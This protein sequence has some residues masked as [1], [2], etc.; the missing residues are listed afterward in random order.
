MKRMEIVYNSLFNIM[1]LKI[2]DKIELSYP[3]S[4]KLKCIN[5]ILDYKSGSLIMDTNYG[6]EYTSLFDLLELGCP[7]K[8]IKREL[9]RELKKIKLSD[10]VLVRRK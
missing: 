3:M 10:I 7:I 5:S 8:S 2:N 4:P 9:I 6:E 1:T